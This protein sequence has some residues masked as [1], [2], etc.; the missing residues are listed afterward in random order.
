M[1]TSLPG[2]SLPLL[3]V[4]TFPGEDQ[5]V[6]LKFL[7]RIRELDRY[8]VIL[9][10]TA[11]NATAPTVAAYRS[12]DWFLLTAM[13]D[14]FAT[15]GLNDAL[16]DIHDVQVNGNPSLKLLGVVLSAVDKRTRLSNILSDYVASTFAPKGA[17]SLKFRTE[18]GRSTVIPSAQKRGKTVLQTDPTHKVANQYR[19]LAREV[20]E[21]V[22]AEDAAKPAAA[23]PSPE[24]AN[25]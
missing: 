7:Q 18:I 13:P 9:L 4:S 19:D 15:R 24:V 12:A 17:P 1:D 3:G 20:L 6:L 16:Q 21:R 22:F 10:D 14:P 8:D 5:D 25:G 23:A 11:P 2:A